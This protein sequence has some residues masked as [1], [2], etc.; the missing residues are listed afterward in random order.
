MTRSDGF[1]LTE[2]L[3]AFAIIA[4]LS[5]VGSFIYISYLEAAKHT[6]LVKTIS[7]VEA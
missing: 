2:V 7:N 3:V 5:S 1:S 6:S 4:V